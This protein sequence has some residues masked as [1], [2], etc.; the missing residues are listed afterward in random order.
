MSKS[1]YQQVQAHV[2]RAGPYTAHIAIDAF[3]SGRITISVPTWTLMEATGLSR[4]ELA[5]AELTVT[6][7]IAARTDTD[8]DLHAWQLFPSSEPAA[9]PQSALSAAA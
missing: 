8:V 6:A 2:V 9:A 4:H 1:N 5:G 3:A 7:N